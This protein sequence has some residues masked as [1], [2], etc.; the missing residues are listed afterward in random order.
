[1][2]ADGRS[3]SFRPLLDRLPLTTQV[4]A[5][6]VPVVTFHGYTA[7]ML[8]DVDTP[9]VKPLGYTYASSFRLG[10]DGSVTNTANGLQ[11]ARGRGGRLT[12]IPRVGISA[13]AD[14]AICPTRRLHRGI[15]ISSI[16][17]N[18][19]LIRHNGSV[20]IQR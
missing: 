9:V 8:R 16:L 4:L 2:A 5:L 19:T 6:G 11:L 18:L 20:L 7:N 3:I 15:L 13:A 17:M 14:V 1:M 12:F 10:S